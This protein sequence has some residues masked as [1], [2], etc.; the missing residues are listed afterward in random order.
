MIF[1]LYKDGYFSYKKFILNNITK[2]ELS[3]NEALVLIKLLDLYL[4]NERTLRV[5]SISE[6][7]NIHGNDVDNILNN[8]LQLDYF[9]MYVENIDGVM[10]EKFTVEPF[11]KRVESL[12]LDDNNNSKEIDK[13]FALIERKTR[14]MLTNNDYTFINSLIEDGNTLDDITNAITTLE[15]G[16]YDIT[17]KNIARQLE[18]NDVKSK[19][20]PRLDDFFKKIGIR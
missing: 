6:A 14:K 11:F 15:K 12:Y 18:H 1:K 19:T 2:L 20:D 13:I 4:T 16:R 7:T 10:T 17:L 5:E 9:S 8:L 3:P